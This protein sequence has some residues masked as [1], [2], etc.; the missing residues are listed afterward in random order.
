MTRNSVIPHLMR[1][2]FVNRDPGQLLCNF[3]D[4]EV[5]R[6]ESAKKKICVIIKKIAN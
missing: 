2:L 3:R 4:D 5:G 1:D 6:I